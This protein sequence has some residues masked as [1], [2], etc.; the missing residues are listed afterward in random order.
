MRAA[1]NKELQLEIRQLAFKVRLPSFVSVSYL[2][3][4][5]EKL[6]QARLLSTTAES[7]R[8]RDTTLHPPTTTPIP[9]RSAPHSPALRPYSPDDILS[10]FAMT[11]RNAATPHTGRSGAH[12]RP[13]EGPALSGLQ[14]LERE[15]QNLAEGIDNFAAQRR[16]MQEMVGADR[17]LPSPRD[18]DETSSQ[19]TAVLPG[20]EKRQLPRAHA[21]T[22]K[23]GAPEAGADPGAEQA[24]RR[25]LEAVR[26]A[27]AA[28]EADLLGEIAALREALREY[29]AKDLSPIPS[30]VALWEDHDREESMELGT[31]LAPTT[32]LWDAEG[33]YVAVADPQYRQ[34]GD[35]SEDIRDPATGAQP[36]PDDDDTR[37]LRDISLLVPLPVSPL[38]PESSSQSRSSLIRDRPPTPFAFDSD[39]EPDKRDTDVATRAVQTE[40]GVDSCST[41]RCACLDRVQAVERELEETRKEVASRDAELVELRRLVTEARM[42]AMRKS[43]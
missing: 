19:A 12:P 15:I 27:S 26:T 37:S 40:D 39:D 1:K 20:P 43:D 34:H 5:C 29:T 16:A 3:L 2:T 4:V 33:G 10:P 9:V 14:L 7:E 32:I 41:S 23:A 28:R 25:E 11:P 18:V 38:S 42:L 22:R 13:R 17:A 31:P 36:T 6:E 24:L 30:E 8:L 35:D 21:D